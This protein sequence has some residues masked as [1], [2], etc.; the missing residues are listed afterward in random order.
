M[1]LFGKIKDSADEYTFSVSQFAKLCGTT[2][3]TLRH[4]YEEGIIVPKVDPE[5]GYHYYSASQITSFY[6]ISTMRQAGCSIKE[7]N[8][9]I[10]NSTKEGIK[11]LGN[12]KILELQNELVIINK[13]INSLKMGM[14][15][16]ENFD[17][18]APGVPFLLDIPSISI[19][20]TPVTVK[21]NAH[22][23]AD[24]AADISRHLAVSAADGSLSS[25]PSGVT[26][27]Y[28]DLLK[29]NYVY[30]NVVSLSLQPSELPNSITYPACKALCCHHESRSQDID[31]SYK[32]ILSY[33]K[34][35]DLKVCSDLYIISLIN[36]YQ[37]NE[38]TYYKYLFICVE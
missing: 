25:F 12:A 31:K 26:I 15:I 11:K 27:A 3:D 4:Y 29:K 18:H 7:I 20:R 10:H 33:I 21:D 14:W 28:E 22:H 1:N 2:R 8:E 17:K 30:N 13:K 23:T 6:F 35:N 36:L 37:K 38:H 34:K 32:K 24:I 19:I 5:N 9:L 16:L